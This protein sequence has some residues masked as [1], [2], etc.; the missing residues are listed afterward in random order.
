M[1]NPKILLWISEN[2]EN[3]IIQRLAKDKLKFIPFT[4]F[5]TKLL[6]EAIKSSTDKQLVSEAKEKLV[7]GGSYE[8]I[9]PEFLT[10][11]NISVG[12]THDFMKAVENNADYELRFPDIASMSKS[13]K[14][15]YDGN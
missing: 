1:Q 15:F 9:N 7:I 2:F 8:V 11:A 12:I 5:E 3:P 6:E 10:G 13:Q 14:E 4:A